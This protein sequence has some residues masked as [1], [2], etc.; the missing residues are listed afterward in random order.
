MR[1]PLGS[2]VFIV[3]MLLVDL[4]VFVAIKTVS[5]NASPKTRAVIFTVFWTISII[6]MVFIALLPYVNYNSWQRPF[7]TYLFAVV[8][9]LFLAKVI[10]VLFFLLDDIRRGLQWLSSKLFFRN[11]E[12][13]TI[14][15]NGITRSTFMSWLGLGLGTTLFGSLIYGFSNQYNYKIKNIDLAFDNL[16]KGF[17]GLKVVHIS[18]IHSGSFMNKEAVKKGVDMI[19]Q[20]GADMILFT[21]DLVND[22]ATEMAEYVDIFS[23]LKAPMGV[24]STFGNH[25]YG[26]YVAWSD[27]GLKLKEGEL[28][29][30]LQAKN[31]ED[32]KA[33]HGKMGWRLLWDEHVAIERGGDKIALMGV[34]NI[35]GKIRFHSYGNMAKAHAGSEKY[36]FKILMSHDPSHWDKEVRSQYP[37]VDLMLSGHT[38]GMQFGIDLP[39]FKWSPVSFVYK[40]WDGLYEEQKQKLYVNPGFGFIGYPGRVGI[41]PEITVI[42][43]V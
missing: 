13:E 38:H 15:E 34:Q 27:K 11:T 28:F 26:D 4:Y 30:P 33:I 12:V 40:Q 1:S 39:W 36:P 32:L 42:T 9:G 17:K 25:D 14:A 24:Y 10:A 2:L 16:P 23:Q 18:D 35:S 41:M 3:V 43:F 31:L 7:R 29:T 21:G 22:K 8:I 37:D 19:N 20:Q 5:Q 6:S